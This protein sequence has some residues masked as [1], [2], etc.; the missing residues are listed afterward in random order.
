MRELSPW[1][2]YV[3]NLT[4]ERR[5]EMDEAVASYVEQIKNAPPPPPGW[6]ELIQT[7]WLCPDKANHRGPAGPNED[8]ATCFRCNSFSF[9]MR[10]EGETWGN[11]LPDCSLELRHEG[12]CAGGGSGHPPAQK[13][14]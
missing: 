8:I 4:A 3:A 14:R 7:P 10:P 5:K 9:A 11:H 12:Y 2:K 1:E 6:W 13:I